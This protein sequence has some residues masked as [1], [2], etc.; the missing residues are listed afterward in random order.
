MPLY[1]QAAKPLYFST[2]LSFRNTVGQ[3]ALQ[4]IILI[5]TGNTGKVDG[6]S[7]TKSIIFLSA[8]S[9]QQGLKKL[10]F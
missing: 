7:D 10:D 6:K 3:H 8:K 1:I 9:K 4:N 2:I 5:I